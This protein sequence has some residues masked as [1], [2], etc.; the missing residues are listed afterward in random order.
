MTNIKIAIIGTRGIPAKY[1]GFETF[2]EEVSKR[3]VEKKIKTIVI[4]DRSNFFSEK[5]YKGVRV[6]NSQYSKP[7][8]PLAFYYDSLKI[9]I[10]EGSNFAIVCGVGGSLVLPFFKKK[11]IV[12]VNPDGLGFKR[13]KYVWWKKFIF[14]TQYLISSKT[15]KYIVCDSIGIKNYYSKY[16]NRLKN[17]SVIEY[18]TNLNPFILKKTKHNKYLFS[19]GIRANKYHLVVSRLEPENNVKMIIQGYL[20]SKK[21]FPLIIVGNT[22]TKYFKE[23]KKYKSNSV[24][25]IGGIYDKNLLM[26][27]RANCLTYLHGHSV[28]GTNP[29]LLEAMGS[30]NVC[31]CHDNEYNREVIQDNGLFFSSASDVTN[32]VEYVEN[33]QNSKQFNKLKVG[34][35]ERAKNYYSWDRIT[36]EYLKLSIK[37]IL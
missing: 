27:L 32:H 6:I 35:Y 9:A 2:A 29:S 19:K 3:L 14:F 10:R 26:N 11:I 28:G 31:I 34:V 30:M 4:G 15:A 24:R 16:F 17:I 8:N 23:L 21:K 37:S 12:S 18:G 22:T 36:D 13:D 5:N 20:F 33:K 25:F 7:N 1:G